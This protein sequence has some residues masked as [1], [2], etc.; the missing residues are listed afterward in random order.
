[1]LSLEASPLRDTIWDIDRGCDQ[2]YQYQF[3]H[4]T[5]LKVGNTSLAVILYR[6]WFL[7][8]HRK[9][10]ICLSCSRDLKYGS[11]HGR[12]TNCYVLAGL[13]TY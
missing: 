13:N 3:Y 7:V 4:L 2:Y 10:C 6:Y 11:C 9:L 12:E 8:I 5:L 1:M